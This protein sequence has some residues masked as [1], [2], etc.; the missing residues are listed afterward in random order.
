MHM[1][2]FKEIPKAGTNAGD[3]D[4][5]EFFARD[6]LKTVGYEILEGPTRG[7]D[8]G[9]DLIVSEKMISGKIMRWLVSCKH[10]A[11]SKK[12]VSGK[13]ELDIETRLKVHNCDGFI[14]F[15]STIPGPSLNTKVKILKHWDLY[16]SAKITSKLL[17][18]VEK[19]GMLIRQ[20]F[21]KSF[22]KIKQ[23]HERIREEK[24]AAVNNLNNKFLDEISEEHLLTASLN[25]IMIFE[26]SKIKDEW[27]GLKWGT[28]RTEL[29]ERLFL[30]SR[31]SNH[32]IDY[33]VLLF[34]QDVAAQTRFGMPEEMAT[35]VSNL[36]LMFCSQVYIVSE[37][38]KNETLVNIAISIAKSLVYDAMIKLES[39]E[40]MMEGLSLLK[41]IY[42]TSR[43]GKDSKY[44]K[45]VREAYRYFEDQLNRNEK[46]YVKQKKLIKLFKE[47]LDRWGMDYPR[48][49]ANF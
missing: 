4:H 6:F 26:L 1:I 43:K 37:D 11:H 30:F 29:L 24:A 49:S 33:E 7:A 20:Y 19:R 41:Y 16:D 21:P 9:A 39:F 38:K 12:A 22:L 14:G 2:D 18:E 27:Y 3:Q 45:F 31:H 48:G 10:F 36:T 23:D 5:F 15:Y 13:D 25:A 17:E 8:N 46:E 28:T 35:A 42:M 47:D 44:K 32:R 34:L 40:I